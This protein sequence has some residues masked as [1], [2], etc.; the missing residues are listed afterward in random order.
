L[1]VGISLSRLASKNNRFSSPLRKLDMRSKMANSPW[2][3]II[4]TIVLSCLKREDWSL[5]ESFKKILK[6]KFDFPHSFYIYLCS[7]FYRKRR[8]GDGR[9]S[10]CPN[11]AHRR[12]ALRAVVIMSD[13]VQNRKNPLRYTQMNNG[14]T[15]NSTFLSKNPELT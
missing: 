15:Q 11:G 2:S 3:T 7:R 14:A 8:R 6:F 9:R 12:V 10:G 5:E 13:T 1:S 4:A